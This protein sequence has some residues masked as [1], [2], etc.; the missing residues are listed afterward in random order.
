MFA[1]RIY[2]NFHVTL[3]EL[4]VASIA[5]TQSLQN[6]NYT[7]ADIKCFSQMKIKQFKHWILFEQG[8]K[9][10]SAFTVLTPLFRLLSL[11]HYE[12]SNIIGI[13]GKCFN[14]Y[15]IEHHQKLANYSI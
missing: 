13:R 9:A 11:T 3:L 12:T 4:I 10:N 7:T 1:L 6:V 2:A 15:L 5:P 14:A 8:N